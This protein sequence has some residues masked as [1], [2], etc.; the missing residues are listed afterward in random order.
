[1]RM[2]SPQW[3]ENR[4][5]GRL[6]AHSD[7]ADMN[8]NM[9][10]KQTLIGCGLCKGKPDLDRNGEIPHTIVTISCDGCSA[11]W[12]HKCLITDFVSDT[13]NDRACYLRN[14]NN[15]R[16]LPTL[17][18]LH[19]FVVLFIAHH[20]HTGSVVGFVDSRTEALVATTSTDDSGT[21]PV[22]GD[23]PVER[24][25]RHG[26]LETLQRAGLLQTQIGPY[27][28]CGVTLG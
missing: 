13:K 25:L 6:G 17:T 8:S 14:Y 10:V 9:G 28:S 22:E 2:K 5:Q 24:H 18:R 11:I 16:S 20:V 7:T 27:V 12:H 4:Q 26:C 21:R 3:R 23:V 1:M 19:A 15:H